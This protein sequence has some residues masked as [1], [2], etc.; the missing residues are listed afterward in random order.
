M[1]FRGLVLEF[2]QYRYTDTDTNISVL[3]REYSNR[4]W[5]PTNLP[6]HFRYQV[7]IYRYDTDTGFIPIFIQI[8]T[9]YPVWLYNHND[10]SVSVSVRYGR[11][12]GYRFNIL[13]TDTAISVS[14]SVYLVPVELY[15]IPA[16]KL[17]SI[18]VLANTLLCQSLQSEKF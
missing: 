5:Y 11:F 13:L 17:V 7:P 6:Y 10:I 12:W 18:P 8:H 14:V 1:Y 15:L 2:D 4:Y 9:Q 3:V 16:S